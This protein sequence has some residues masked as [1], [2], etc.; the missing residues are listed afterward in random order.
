MDIHKK[1]YSEAVVHERNSYLTRSYLQMQQVAAAPTRE[2]T[3]DLSF[4]RVKGMARF[5]ESNPE[6]HFDS[7]MTDI[8]CGLHSP[9]TVLVYMLTGNGHEIQ[10]Y[11]GISSERKDALL[12]SLVGSYPFISLE[13]APNCMKRLADCG[14][15][16]M[17][18]GQPTRKTDGN[19]SSQIERICR[20]MNHSNGSWSY[21]VLSRGISAFVTEQCRNRLIQEMSSLSG[22]LHNNQT[23][24]VG[25][26]ITR[27]K[28]QFLHQRYMK[29]LECAEMNL[30]IG[31]GQGMWST[32]VYYSGASLEAGRRL[33][34][35]LVSVYAGEQ[36]EPEAVS[37]MEYPRIADLLTPQ[38]SFP[39][40]TL[41]AR[42]QAECHPVGSWQLGGEG[43]V[44]QSPFIQQYQT[45]LN[46]GQLA[47]W[48]QIPRKEIPGY[49]LSPYV[50]FDTNER[51]A[52]DFS[53]GEIMSDVSPSG[54]HSDQKR[55]PSYPYQ[56]KTEDFNKHIL[57]LGM[58]G[59]GKSNSTMGMLLQLWEKGIP[60][61]VIEAAKREYYSMIN[62]K[63]GEN[64]TLLQDMLLFTPGREE[65]QSSIPFR[66]NPFEIAGNGSE[67]IQ[68]HIDYILSVFKASFDLFPP[69]PQILEA[70]VYRVYQDLGWD[71]L[72]NRNVYGM[73]WY[74]TLDELYE[75]VDPIVT[76][77]GYDA[78]LRSDIM[79]A[80]Q[81]RIHSLRLG[82]KGA[83][84]NNRTSTSIEQWIRRPVV[85]ELEDIGDDD[86]KSFIIA[87]LL[88]QMYEYRKSSMHNQI[89]SSSPFQHLLVIEEAHRLLANMP[90][91]NDNPRAQ[92]IQFFSNL[93]SEIRSYGQG[94]LLSEQMPSKITPDALRNTNLKL[95]HRVTTADDRKLIGGA[96]A[97]TPEQMEYISNL[98]VGQAAMF[99]DGDYRPKLVQMPLVQKLGGPQEWK[100]RHD[101]VKLMRP[102]AEQLIPKSRE[103]G[104]CLYCG[105]S[106]RGA[107]VRKL[108]IRHK[109]HEE[110]ARKWAT[111]KARLWGT[112][113]KTICTR[114][115]QFISFLERHRHLEGMSGPERY[116]VVTSLLAFTKIGDDLRSRSILLYGKQY[117]ASSGETSHGS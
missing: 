6:I 94:I 33:R 21:I 48:S 32:A 47:T 66:L 92:A 68:T 110:M 61:L 50:E 106:C 109:W 76:E 40:L 62:Y 28:H 53:V 57:V 1:L 85:I 55:T 15:G 112:N 69:M 75:K 3:G 98:K 30:A 101:I 51:A 54:I 82:S 52:G 65:P 103:E 107:L 24:S 86:V 116:C 71:V 41:P 22:Y 90:P 59:F 35:L 105:T 93:L 10:L 104:E 46:S 13:W 67:T 77:R 80:V 78:R 9:N 34:S 114:L 27:E 100:T 95:V 7:I 17:I 43:V 11:L 38:L 36:S 45:P 97:M 117:I 8:L 111:D 96:M 70:C 29:N 14:S 84:L 42:V 108:V 56:M 19:A 83:L 20:S 31:G 64:R 81:T 113:V 44:F 12:G 73:N 115:H 89:E 99:S 5:W 25:G 2:S 63:Y 79:A 60:F 26:R 18:V 16:G 49:S 4:F 37:A 88:I 91:G 87:V 39:G 74:P 102:R 72:E 58:T 23:E